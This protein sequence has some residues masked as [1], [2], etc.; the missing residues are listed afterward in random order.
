MG[1]LSLDWITG[2]AWYSLNLD[3]ITGRV[4]E[5]LQPIEDAEGQNQDASGKT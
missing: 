4:K 2:R 5:H 3:W 1:I